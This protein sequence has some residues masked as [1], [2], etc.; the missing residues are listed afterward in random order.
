[1]APRTRLQKSFAS[2]V[3]S[4]SQNEIPYQVLFDLQQKFS[5]L[6]KEN[7]ELKAKLHDL[8]NR[9]NHIEKETEGKTGELVKNV[10]DECMLSP[11][12][13]LVSTVKD[14][15]DN[16]MD[17]K[18]IDKVEAH[19]NLEMSEQRLRDRNVLKLRLGGLPPDWDR[20]ER[21]FPI[22]KSTFSEIDWITPTCIANSG[23]HAILTFKTK[24]DKIEILKQTRKLKGTKKWISEQL[25]LT[26]LRQRPAELEKVKAARKIG[27]WAVYREG[28]AIV[29]DFKVHDPGSQP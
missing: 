2:I 28:I 24:E 10:L 18:V 13:Q 29:R 25:T 23:E 1:M 3:A 27:K 7:L 12:T 16:T 5:L 4:T 8:E 6:Q 21:C 19:V 9:V 11:P 20:E 26:Q 17:A 14:I 22:I 15:I